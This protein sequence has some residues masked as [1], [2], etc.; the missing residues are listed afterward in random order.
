[1][2]FSQI[3]WDVYPQIKLT[4]QIP[5]IKYITDY[6]S[7]IH[8]MNYIFSTKKEIMHLNPSNESQILHLNQYN[9]S[10][11]FLK[12]KTNLRQRD[13]RPASMHART[14]G[15]GASGRRPP[16]PPSPPLRIWRRGARGRRR[17][18]PV[19]TAPTHPPSRPPSG[20]R[21]PREQEER[22]W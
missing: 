20:R 7:H 12:K 1:M 19:A 16:L 13:A 21:R 4:S 8:A 2:I 22:T 9:E 3:Q 17:A 15:E 10:Q 5:Q 14:A 18:R 6:T 11:F